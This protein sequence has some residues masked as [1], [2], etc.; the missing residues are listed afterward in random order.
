LSY[1][2]PS[3]TIYNAIASSRPDLIDVLAQ[4]D[5]PVF[6]STQNPPYQLRPMLFYHE[7]RIILN[8]SEVHVKMDPKFRR[9]HCIPNLS[10]QQR[11]ALDLVLTVAK[12]YSFTLDTQYGD[13]RYINNLSILHARG[14]F[15][16]DRQS[17]R[18]LV[19]LYL[20]NDEI[21]WDIP[22]MLQKTWDSVYGENETIDEIYPIE[23]VPV[24]APPLY[25]F[26]N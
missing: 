11:E 17:H 2:A 1:I 8:I 19:R 15:R 22:P 23:P 4:P 3:W 13:I 7:E 20:R 12:K 6:D 5:W 24:I 26:D 10:E 18:H 9:A 25:R 21:G 16:D 14:E